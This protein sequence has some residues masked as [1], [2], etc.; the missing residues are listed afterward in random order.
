[1]LTKDILGIIA[2]IVIGLAALKLLGDPRFKT[3]IREGFESPIKEEP[4]PYTE[5]S[6]LS[7]DDKKTG[8]AH[9]LKGTIEITRPYNMVGTLTAQRCYEQD[10]HVIPEKLGDYSQ[11]TN[12][13]V[14][15]NPDSCS[16]PF[17]EMV[18]SFYAPR[19]GA[20]GAPVPV[21]S[22]APYSTTCEFAQ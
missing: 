7:P 12:N 3:Y 20:I 11:R 19:E 18:G 2:L 4:V 16:A 8:P 10:G 6:R 13:Y 1:M 17:K 21:G 9:L 22:K 5:P 15:T 14:H